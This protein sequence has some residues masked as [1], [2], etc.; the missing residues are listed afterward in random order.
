MERA[1]RQVAAQSARIG[2][3]KADLLPRFQLIGSVGLSA[4]DAANF[5][6]GHSFE[7]FGGPR[8]DWPILNYGRITN[9]VRVEDATFQELAAAYANTVLRA[10]QEVEDAV[11]GYLRGAEQVAHLIRGVA[12]ANRAV[13]LS[14][15]QYREGAAD[16]TTVLTRQQSKLREDDSLT[17]SRGSVTLSAIALYKALGGGWE[18]REG[19]D[20]VP[21][22]VRQEM[23]ARTGWGGMLD[24]EAQADDVKAAGASTV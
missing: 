6:E 19:G 11:A 22:D 16:Y 5:F 9:A 13:D 14:L 17:T 4:E 2:V 10:Q 23:R 18:L 20:F 24:S 21:E 12:A 15:I 7:S 3:A 8:F 1:E